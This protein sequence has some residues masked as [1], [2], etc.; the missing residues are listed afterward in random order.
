MAIGNIAEKLRAL[1]KANYRETEPLEL[2]DGTKLILSNLN[3]KEDRDIGDYLH[4]HLGGSIGH[5]GKIE[6]LTY[7]IRWIH[8]PGED[9]I[10]LRGVEFIDTGDMVVA[11]DGSTVS[12][13]K[14]K[15]VFMRD[16]VESWPDILLDQLY[17]RFVRLVESL[18]EDVSRG[19]KV[20]MT[21]EV[22]LS[23]IRSKADEL[24]GLIRKARE[25][26]LTVEGI[27]DFSINPGA[28]A[29]SHDKLAEALKS[30]GAPT[31]PTLVQQALRDPVSRT[32][33]EEAIDAHI[34]RDMRENP[35]TYRANQP[36]P[37][38]AP[39]AVAP[40]RIRQ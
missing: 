7:T 27:Y 14:P 22:I 21:G 18:E 3:G 29:G 36:V 20:E 1:K 9:P 30:V 35:E 38:Q 25:M 28:V 2:P 4:Q 39:D 34:D 37:V 5:W 13:K 17:A 10:D 24:E 16:I 23:R 33:E 12:V 32:P 31:D 19:I 11:P 6:T 26:G 8:V 40:K 15:N